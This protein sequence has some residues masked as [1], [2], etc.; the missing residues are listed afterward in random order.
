[1]AVGLITLTNPCL[2]SPSLTLA[3]CHCCCSIPLPYHSIIVVLIIVHSKISVWIIVTCQINSLVWTLVWTQLTFSLSTIH[4]PHYF[5]ALFVF[6][7]NL[8]S[9]VNPN[10][11][12]SCPVS[13]RCSFLIVFWLVFANIEWRHHFCCW[14]H[15]FIKENFRVFLT[16]LGIF[17]WSFY[18]SWRQG[19]L[20]GPYTLLYSFDAKFH[21]DSEFCFPGSCIALCPLL[22]PNTC[23]Y[24]FDANFHGDSEFRILPILFSSSQ[25]SRQKIFITVYGCFCV[26]TRSSGSLAT[27]DW[28][29]DFLNS[30]FW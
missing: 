12:V 30:I 2:L 1:L 27:T 14:C 4:H 7:F 16:N 23:L 19:N 13:R 3:C 21:A 26:F 6:T 20:L 18:G 22:G 25:N 9:G 28:V 10:P 15:H 11:I 24:S 29:V 5:L 8:H 17:W